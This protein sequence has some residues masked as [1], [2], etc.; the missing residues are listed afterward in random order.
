MLRGG[1]TT[2]KTGSGDDSERYRF[3]RFDIIE[4]PKTEFDHLPDGDVETFPSEEKAEEAKKERVEG[5]G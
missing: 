1:V 2:G 3:D 4:G 5:N